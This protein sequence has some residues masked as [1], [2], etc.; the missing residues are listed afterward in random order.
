MPMKIFYRFV[1]VLIFV[2]SSLRMFS[3]DFAGMGIA[4]EDKAFLNWYNLDC[5][6]DKI[7]GTSADKAYRELLTRL[8]PAQKVIVAVIDGGVD[9]SHDDLEGKIWTNPNEV[10]GNGV[11]DDNNGYVDDL[12]GWNFLGNPNGENVLYENYEQVRIIRNLRS[13]FENHNEAFSLDNADKAAYNLF[14]QSRHQYEEELAEYTNQLYN[15]VMFEK[16]IRNADSLIQD[17]LGNKNPSMA[18][19]EGIQTSDPK[20]T[21]AASLRLKMHQNQFSDKDFQAYKDHIRTHLDYYLNTEFDARVTIADNP[22]DITDNLYGNSDVT[23]PSAGHGTAVA[24]IIAAGRNNFGIDGIAESAQIMAL[25]VVPKGDE[26]DKDVALAIRNAVDNGARIINM[27]F[28]K[29]FSPEKFMVDEAL[30]YAEAHNVLLVHASG[31][32]ALNLDLA[33]RYPSC[34][35]SDGTRIQSWLSVGATGRNPGRNLVGDFSNYGMNQVDLFAPGVDI[36]SLSPGNEY[37][38]GDGTSFASPVVAGVAALVWSYYPDF[39][40]LEIK[41][42]LLKSVTRFTGK[43]YVPQL[44]SE[45]RKKSKLSM[46]SSSGG[47]VNAYEAL[48]LAGKLYKNQAEN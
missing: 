21:Q 8:V 28:G 46:L 36:L 25:R 44:E 45:V 42:I 3:Q 17:Y 24:G 9:I 2:F 20:L 10:A 48:K 18:D 39:T 5:A 7:L 31:N 16:R 35:L 23:G 37:D 41:D 33:E 13:R 38:R 4:T 14:L 15:I 27:S 22:L 32:K 30:R 26:R 1:P 40:A 6:H 29:D 11:D 19:I 12:H 47:V 34:M 43:V